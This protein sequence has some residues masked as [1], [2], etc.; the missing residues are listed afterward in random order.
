MR[1]STAIKN[2]G[3]VCVQT[4]SGLAKDWSR[5]GYEERDNFEKHI[6]ALSLRTM[7]ILISELLKGEKY[8]QVHRVVKSMLED[9]LP[10]LRVTGSL[11]SEIEDLYEMDISDLKELRGKIVN[12]NR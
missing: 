6:L 1:R 11:E 8:E 12:L 7:G 4:N 5:L 9:I 10:E 3:N 2:K